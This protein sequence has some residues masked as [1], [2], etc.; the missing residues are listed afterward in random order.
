MPEHAPPHP[1]P[2]WRAGQWLLARWTALSAGRPWLRG[3][4]LRVYLPLFVLFS[5][6]RLAVRASGLRFN[7]DLGWMFLADPAALSSRLLET[8]FYFH[9]FAPGTNILT[10]LLLKL[11]PAHLQAAAATVFFASGYL[12]LVSMFHL[13]RTIGLRPR[14]ALLLSVTFALLPQSIY[15][16]NLY[17]YTHLC[18]SLSCLAA[19]LFIRALRMGSWRSWLAFFGTCSLLGWLYTTY[20]LV[21]F[22]MLVAGGLLLADR[23]RRRRVLMGAAAPAALFIALYLKNYWVFGVFGATTW[24][25]ANL[26]LATTHRM[27]PALRESWIRDGK[28]SP[29]AA[30]SVF[31]PPDK[32]L[33]FF[34]SDV[35]FPWPGSN[36]LWRP[37]VR[38]PNYN[39]GLF[40][41]VNRQRRE[42][43]LQ[44]I[45]SRPLDYVATVLGKNL[46]GLFGSSTHWH[47]RDA[48][49]RAPHYQHRQALGA[50]ERA[51]DALVHRLPIR[52]VGLYTLLPVFCAWALRSVWRGFRWRESVRD[53][54]TELLAFCL[55][56]VLFVVGASC[57]F[58]AQEASR[59]RYGVEPFIWIIV[60]AG[61]LAAR[62]RS[63]GAEAGGTERA[64]LDGGPRE[65]GTPPL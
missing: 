1:P 43:S 4:L 29:Y 58:T 13:A 7:L 38:E 2:P 35:H 5:A 44:F 65:R 40:L 63:G 24:G 28:L 22:C 31:A 11:A 19:V 30:I 59:Y 42:D 52:G 20:H 37:S 33:R 50:Y 23:G 26:T 41:A 48:S 47:P 3:A 6:T 10:G 34:S 16:E 56:Q 55:F 15:F 12:L 45:R 39:H 21:W 53:R 17:L 60:A 25:G 32:Y 14:S 64:E 57:L 61:L 54:R 9:A 18:T 36:E 49:P 46:P 51:Y 8:V 62:Q 27:Q